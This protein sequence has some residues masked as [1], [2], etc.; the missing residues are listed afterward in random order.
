MFATLDPKLRSVGL[1]SK[2]SV[3]LSDTVGFIRNLPHTLVSAFR[4]TLEEVQR[5]TLVLQVSDASNPLSAEQDAQVDKVLKELGADGK[6][7]LRVKN[8]IDLLAAG[9]R[10]VLQNNERTVYVSAAKGIGVE[11]LLERIDRLLEDDRPSRVRLKVPQREGKLLAMLE[12]KA[13]IVSRTYREGN[14]HLEIEAP[15]SV[16]RGVREF[17][18]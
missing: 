10:E 6:P 15:Q 8:K 12:A 13:I 14:V 5:A 9:E 2:R 16:L 3:L 4:A 17:V 18:K 7:R 1:P 11:V